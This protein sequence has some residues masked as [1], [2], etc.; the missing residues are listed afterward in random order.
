MANIIF[1]FKHNNIIDFNKD[2][3]LSAVYRLQPKTEY[4]IVDHDF[5]KRRIPKKS[6]ISFNYVSDKLVEVSWFAKF[7]DN[8]FK[9]HC[10]ID[11]EQLLEL[12][13]DVMVIGYK[14]EEKV[15]SALLK[16]E[17][18]AKNVASVTTLCSLQN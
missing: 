13:F 3:F 11:D 16:F 5:I 2:Y 7:D 1:G 9:P 12:A 10:I 18:Q 6:F 15:G 14:K 17:N 8:K 4:N